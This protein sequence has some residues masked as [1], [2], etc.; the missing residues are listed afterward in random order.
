[1]ADDYAFFVWGL[2]ELYETTFE[3]EHLITALALQ[4]EMIEHFWDAQAGGFYFTADDAEKLLVRQKEI[5]DG[6]VPSGNS[7]AMLNLLRLAR[8][9]GQS[10]FEDKALGIARAFAES[11]SRVPSAYTQLLTAVAFARSPSYEIVIA[12]DPQAED[13]KEMIAALRRAFIPNKVVVLRPADK[14]SAAITAIAPYTREHTAIDGRATAYV[15]RNYAC[16][17][18]TTSVDKMLELLNVKK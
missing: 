10:T 12:G 15:C 13:T 7:I 17:L 16:N 2:L 18:P 5:Y 4:H 14:R 11:V 8:M 3:A 6:A 9:T 1:M